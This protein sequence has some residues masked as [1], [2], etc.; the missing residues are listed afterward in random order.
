MPDKHMGNS[1]FEHVAHGVERFM[2][3]RV[4]RSQLLSPLGCPCKHH[5]GL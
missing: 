3:E 1:C 2:Q 4:V 5:M